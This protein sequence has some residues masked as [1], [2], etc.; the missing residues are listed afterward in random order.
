MRHAVNQLSTTGETTYPQAV[1]DQCVTAGLLTSDFE[2]T[3]AGFSESADHGRTLDKQ[4]LKSR[5]IER[6]RRSQWERGTLR[7]LVAD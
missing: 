5:F 6:E 7:D 2:P 4:R 3:A 1:I